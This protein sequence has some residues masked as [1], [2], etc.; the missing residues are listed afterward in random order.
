MQ[1]N[2]TFHRYGLEIYNCYAESGLRAFPHV[3]F[4][5]AVADATD[6]I[7]EVPDLA[8]WYEK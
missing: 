2:G 4:E 6:G 3:P 1:E 7:E 5:E 8:G